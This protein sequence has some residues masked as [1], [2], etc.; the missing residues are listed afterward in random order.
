MVP[1][2][3]VV[4]R[5]PSGSDA[6]DL[7]EFILPVRAQRRPVHAGGPAGDPRRPVSTGGAVAERNFRWGCRSSSFSTFLS[8]FP[9][10][11]V[12]MVVQCIL[13]GG[14]DTWSGATVAIGST[15]IILAL[16]VLTNPIC[17][18]AEKRW[19]RGIVGAPQLP[20]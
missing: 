10:T 1:V 19:S 18:N 15:G 8:T 6:E 5:A 12:P 9:S 4:V 16:P 13:A 20:A 3:L 11:G 17:R 2:K 7:G 14:R